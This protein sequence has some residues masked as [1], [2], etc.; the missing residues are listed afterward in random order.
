MHECSGGDRRCTGSIT[1]ADLVHSSNPDV[2]AAVVDV[3]GLW[4]DYDR[5]TGSNDKVRL[6]EWWPEPHVSCLAFNA[7]FDHLAGNVLQALLALNVTADLR[8]AW[9]WNTKQIYLSVYVTFV[10]KQNQ[11]NQAVIW[12]QIFQHKVHP[13]TTLLYKVQRRHTC[14]A[15]SAAATALLHCLEKV[16]VPSGC[17]A[18]Q[19]RPALNRA[20]FDPPPALLLQEDAVLQQSHLTHSHPSNILKLR[21]PDKNAVLS[22]PFELKDQG[23]N[24][25]GLPY[26]VTVAWNTMPKVGGLLSNQTRQCHCMRRNQEHALHRLQ[27]PSCVNVG[28]FQVRASLLCLPAWP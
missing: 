1:P 3:Q 19:D 5:W 10:T 16:R 23:A 24:L 4:R 28:P 22:Y 17:E 9:T 18:W 14:F 11:L 13:L 20:A 21:S 7:V 25:R 8:S 26:N 12:N 27:E 6:H 2:S 15:C